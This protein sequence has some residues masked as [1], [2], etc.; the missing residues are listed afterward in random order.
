MK[1]SSQQKQ[2]GNDQNDP[3]QHGK[4]KMHLGLLSRFYANHTA[5]AQS[6]PSV[7]RISTRLFHANRKPLDTGP[8]PI[9][10]TT[11]T[12]AWQSA[13]AFPFLH[14]LASGCIVPSASG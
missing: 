9:V 6:C 1:S 3:L 10:R 14:K 2:R 4:G 13:G 7:A 12:T 5:Q 8:A 11:V